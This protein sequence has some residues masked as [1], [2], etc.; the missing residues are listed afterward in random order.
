MKRYLFKN[1]KQ[2]DRQGL[3][4][5]IV[6]D[7]KIRTVKNKDYYIGLNQSFSEIVDLHGNYLLPSFT[8]AHMHLSLYTILFSAVD[9]RNCISI[10]ELQ[11]KLKNETGREVIIGWGFDHE[12]F[13]EERMPNRV[14]LDS[15]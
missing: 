10:K 14:D 11:D 15:V 9:L 1:F 3:W 6:E 8:D 7:G 12:K 5:L 4:S 13:Q 2:I